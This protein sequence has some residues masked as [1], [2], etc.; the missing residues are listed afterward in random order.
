MPKGQELCPKKKT[1]WY[2]CPFWPQRRWKN[3][4]HLRMQNQGSC[5]WAALP[6]FMMS[7]GETWPSLHRCTHATSR[8]H[9]L[10]SILHLPAQ[11]A[12]AL[13]FTALPP[14]LYFRSSVQKLPFYHFPP[15]LSPPS[16]PFRLLEKQI[17]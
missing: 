1:Q 6:G 12:L 3:C 7:P 17:H 4:Q 2:C 9:S 5:I 8:S 13:S 11:Q 14:N 10:N 15:T 16:M